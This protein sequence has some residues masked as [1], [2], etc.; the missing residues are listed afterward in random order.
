MLTLTDSANTVVTT[1][2][3]RTP[4][5]KDAGLRISTD[6]A[7]AGEF[8]VAIAP[9]PEPTDTVVPSAGA[10]VYLEEKA[11]IALDD[12]VLDAQFT[13]DGSVRFAIGTQ[14]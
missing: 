1:I 6:E 10:K 9:A 13:D 2:T 5:I 12:K 14:E 3:E 8:A 11:A 7:Q 4:D